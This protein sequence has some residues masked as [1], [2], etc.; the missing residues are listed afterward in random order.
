MRPFR[1][2]NRRFVGNRATGA[3][4]GKK[5][6]MLFSRA[7]LGFNDVDDG[8]G[9]RNGSLIQLFFI[10]ELVIFTWARSDR[11]SRVIFDSKGHSQKSLHVFLIFSFS[12]Y[13]CLGPW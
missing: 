8:S 4:K 9:S 11:C 6:R 10:L 13:F 7:S 2:K 1:L 3:H 12:K 5:I